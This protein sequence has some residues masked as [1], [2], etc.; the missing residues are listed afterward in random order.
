MF[1]SKP[2]Y[3]IVDEITPTKTSCELEYDTKSLEILDWKLENTQ[4]QC[5]FLLRKHVITYE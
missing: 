4:I 1:P 3:A 5:K 2:L